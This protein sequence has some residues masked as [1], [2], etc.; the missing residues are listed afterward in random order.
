MRRGFFGG[1]GRKRPH[2]CRVVHEQSR[3]CRP[4]EGGRLIVRPL[5]HG[6]LVTVV[7]FGTAWA[8]IALV[9]RK[10]REVHTAQVHAGLKRTALAAAATLDGDLHR[11]FVDRSQ[12]GSAEYARAIKPLRRILETVDGVRYVYTVILRDD[13]VYFVLDATPPG[14]A[15]GDGLVDHSG[16]MDPYQDADPAMLAALRAGRATTT[17][18]PFADAWGTF[19]TGYAPFFDSAGEQVGVVGV[20]IPVDEYYQR[21]A[22][23]RRTAYWGFLPATI[24]SLAAGSVVF[25]LRRAKLRA[26]RERR[27]SVVELRAS[28]EYHRRIF[29][30]VTD[31]L[32]ITDG[33]GRIV[34]ANPAACRMHGF[35]REELVGLAGR[36]IIHPDCHDL[37]RRFCVELPQGKPFHVEARDLRHDGSVF[38]VE[39]R[40]TM[41]AFRGRQHLL[42]VVQDITA[43]KQTERELQRARAAAEAANQAKSDFLA[44]MSHEIRTPLTAI[45][46]FAEDRKSVV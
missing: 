33:E 32:L 3:D 26:E 30:S 35:T 23:V 43:R 27:R 16:I 46:G 12:E 29:E 14:D 5:L 41:V 45:L 17:D 4:E 36:A 25:L 13:N 38:D 34:D 31:G 37:F 39:V 21:L 40:G 15:N 28:E 1:R 22:S 11:T 10:A 8:S 19:L 7:L 24:V 2:R 20:D 44:R 18:R 42:A 6:L 9:Y